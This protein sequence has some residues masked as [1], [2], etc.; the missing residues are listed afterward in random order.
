M[1]GRGLL[2]SAGHPLGAGA[3]GADHGRAGGRGN[4]Q[5]LVV[6]AL[7]SD[8]LHPAV[9]SERQRGVVIVEPFVR[10]IDEALGA[11][12]V[13]RSVGGEVRE[14]LGERRAIRRH[15]IP[16]EQAGG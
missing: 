13:R 7:G 16:P 1:C 2:S 5:T 10:L 8:H 11:L 14:R 9:R 15:Q 6:V 4:T 12:G 3:V